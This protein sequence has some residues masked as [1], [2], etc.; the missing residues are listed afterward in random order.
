VIELE[1]GTAECVTSVSDFTTFAMDG[2]HSCRTRCLFSWMFLELFRA[3]SV[4]GLFCPLSSGV[5][6][7]PLQFWLLLTKG[8][9]PLQEM[10]VSL[11][12]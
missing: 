7:K 10:V 11:V 4:K 12:S 9:I 3:G 2:N 8:L 6:Q 1:H 5:P